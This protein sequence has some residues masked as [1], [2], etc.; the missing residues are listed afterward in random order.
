MRD[1]GRSGL[2]LDAV[3]AVLTL[4]AALVAVAL[5]GDEA[6]WTYWLLFVPVAVACLPLALPPGR[7]R[8]PGRIAAA[9]LLFA[10]CA[11]AAASVGMLYLPAA[12]A[13]T[14]AATRKGAPQAR[15]PLRSND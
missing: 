7:P 5:V 15:R 13:M 8:R 2:M 12:V 14:V 4:A 6:W 1:G 9:I 11:V 10:W 3:A